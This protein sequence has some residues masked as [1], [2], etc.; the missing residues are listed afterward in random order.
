MKAKIKYTVFEWREEHWVCYSDY[1]DTKK[2]AQR[3]INKLSD[4]DM[5]ED[6][7]YRFFKIEKLYTI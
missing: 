5:N 1:Y 6:N 7:T 3:V 2:E 4:E